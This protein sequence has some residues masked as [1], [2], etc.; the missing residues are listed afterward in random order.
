MSKICKR[1]FWSSAGITIVAVIAI[2]I[3]W[4]SLNTPTAKAVAGD[5]ATSGIQL[6][7]M[8]SN[9]K[10]DMITVGIINPN[11]ETWARVGVSPYGLGV[12]YNG[13]TVSISSVAIT[14]PSADPAILEIGLDENDPDLLID[15][16]ASLIELTYT[17]VGG[18]ATCTN[19][20]QD[21]VDEEMATIATG[22]SGPADTELDIA[23]PQI[24]EFSYN[25]DDADGKIDSI[26]PIFTETVTAASVLGA[27]DL[28]LTNVGDFTGAAFGALATD[29]ITG[30]VS[31]VTVLLG[32][33]ATA[34]D[35][36]DGSGTIAI[37]SQNAFSLT[38]GTNTNN[39]LGAQAQA[40]FLDNAAPQIQQFLYRD[41][42]ADG[43]V[44]R[45][46]VS[47]TETVT[48]ASVLGANDLVFTNVGDFT[49]AAFGALATDLITGSVSSVTVPFGTEASVV[50]TYDSSGTIAISSQNAFSLTDAK[51]TNATLGAQSN[52]TF[53]DQANPVIKTVT[54]TDASSAQSRTNSVA[55]TF[56]EPM[57][58]DTW[59]EGTEFDSSPD[60]SG[61]SGTWSGSGNLTMTLTHA[62]FLCAQT[63]TVSFTPAQITATNGTAPLYKELNNA[64]TAPI[65]ATHTFTTMSCSS[66]SS[67]SSSSSSDDDDTTT[68]EDTTTD[69]ED[70]TTDTDEDTTS[71]TD[72]EVTTPTTGEQTYSPVT[73][74]LED[75]S[76]VTAGDF[77]KSPYFSTVYFVT[78]EL[79]RRP[80][81]DSQTYFTYADSYDEVVTVTDATLTTLK[82]GSVMLPNP[83]VVL[84]KIQSD[85]KTY[86]VDESNNLR[87]ITTEAVATSLYGSHW[88]D[89]IIDIEPTFFTKF[90]TGASISGASDVTV[91]DSMKTRAELAE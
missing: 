28:T 84:V 86:A 44:D 33:E 42:D 66:S 23:K 11:L 52:A 73:G 54:P 17:Q 71:D 69:E 56:S 35:T 62:P 77:I 27:N 18:G 55:Y 72:E 46:L 49:D 10:I 68:E 79:T 24:K 16:S 30:S 9:G 70:A 26:S 12:K 51:N 39:T 57:V 34:K 21:Q 25:D 76:V 15:T 36:G 88:A 74:E 45:M 37:S 3:A 85:P 58:G 13:N 80:F 50:D 8:N 53:L 4:N 47:F 48:A 2:G 38:D 63:Y 20:I 82:L 40:S 1:R 7:D 43:R 31:S 91:S 67:T 14:S 59:V 87:W 65:G 90:G 41:I 75:I 32:T 19:C 5:G 60:G 29:L 89:Y 6:L 64:S 61:W 78:D 83:G 22:D 81:M